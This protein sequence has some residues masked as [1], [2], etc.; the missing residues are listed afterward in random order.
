MV[1]ILFLPKLPKSF[2][3]MERISKYLATAGVASRRKCEE[4]VLQGRVSL[5]GKT[6]T[7]LGTQVDPFK[8]SV[9]LDG[10]QIGQR[11]QMVVY[12]LNKPAGFHCTADERVKKRAID[13]IASHAPRL[14]TVGRL[15]KETEGLILVT[16]DGALAH[17]IMHPSF[18]IHKEYIA[19]VNKEIT[20]EMLVNLSQGVEV[21]GFKIIPVKVEKVRKGTVRVVIV[22]GR[23]HEVRLLLSAYGLDVLH[24]QRVRIGGLHMGS[25]PKGAYRQLSGS[26]IEAIFS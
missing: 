25:M 22:D 5:N 26:E 17:K 13:L 16:N 1:V 3:S 4:I 15:D 19:K 18:E 8:D 11:P 23:K 12:A 7:E 9:L 10:N 21:D 2:K 6:V 14:F 24:L 20:H